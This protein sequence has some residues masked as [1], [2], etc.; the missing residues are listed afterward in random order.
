VLRTSDCI[1]AE[2]ERPT[3]STMATFNLN[4]I[5]A[6]LPPPGHTSNF[7][8][9]EDMHQTVF[10]V[11]V[12]TMILTVT[13]LA[14]RIYTKTVILKEMRAEECKWV[15]LLRLEPMLTGNRACYSRNRGHYHL[16]LDV[17][18]CLVKRLLSTLVRCPI[19]R[20]P[21]SLLRMSPLEFPSSA[22]V[23]TATR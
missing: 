16:G 8:N 21:K 19:V 4:N 17:R 10:A 6:M 23:L 2:P 3:K 11:G 5:P 22:D 9:P 15:G 20:G 13:A 12:A 14:I 18:L 1:L 7:D